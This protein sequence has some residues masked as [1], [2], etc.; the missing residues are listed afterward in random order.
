MGE[1][2]VAS[3][4]TSAR[5]VALATALVL[6]ALVFVVVQL[7]R[8]GAQAITDC[9]RALAAGDTITA[10]ERARD[11]ALAVAPGSPYPDQGL[12]RLKSLA[13]AAETHGSFDQAAAAW[14]A[15]WT[16][17][18]STRSE[19]RESGRLAEAGRGLVRV[20]TR[21]CEGNQA[22]VPATCGA[23]VQA[24]LAEDDLPSLSSFGGIAFGAIAFAGGGVMAAQERDRRRRLASLV[25][26]ALGLTTLVLTFAT[27]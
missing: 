15:I 23:A 10:I 25:V 27:R 20:A 13:E 11:A 9:D 2:G 6:A 26:L 14:R 5:W 19:S 1:P 16:A 17:I 7:R 18:R 21:V 4:G 24:A 22:R 3:R 12:T 8:N